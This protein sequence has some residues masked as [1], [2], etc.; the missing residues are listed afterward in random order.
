MRVHNH[1]YVGRVKGDAPHAAHAARMPQQIN[2][3]MPDRRIRIIKAITSMYTTTTTAIILRHEQ[4]LRAHRAHGARGRA[5]GRRRAPRRAIRVAQLEHGRRAAVPVA[6]AVARA[7]VADARA[8][9]E[10]RAERVRLARRGAEPGRG[11]DVGGGCRARECCRGRLA[12]VLPGVVLLE[13]VDDQGEDQTEAEYSS[14]CAAY[15]CGC[16]AWLV[17]RTLDWSGRGG[18]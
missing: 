8:A 3:P 10:R 18:G 7:A 15:Y 13:E 12:S 16:I 1:V 6:V 11:G 5:A 17:A 9:H 14:D 4:T 2:R